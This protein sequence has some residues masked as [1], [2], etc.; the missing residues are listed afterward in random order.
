MTGDVD[1]AVVTLALLMGGCQRVPCAD[2]SLP[3]QGHHSGQYNVSEY[4]YYA[5][6]EVSAKLD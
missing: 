1:G 6:N 2:S 3:S 4:E 5:Y